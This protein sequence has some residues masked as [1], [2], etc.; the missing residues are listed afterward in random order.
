MSTIPVYIN[1]YN[2]LATVRAMVAYLLRVPQVEPVIVD[3]A[4]TYPPLLEWYAECPVRVVRLDCNLGPLGVWS[5][6]VDLHAS[7]YFGVTDP[8]LD[9][10]GIPV[11]CVEILCGGLDRYDDVKK[12]GLS[13]EIDDLPDTPVAARAREYEA[14]YWQVR[15]DNAFY[16]ANIDTTFAM[17]RGT[18]ASW[19]GYGPA[20]RA[21]RPYTARH[22]PWYVT[23]D[24]VTDEDLY[25]WEHCKGGVSYWG[26]Q[27]KHE[28]G[29]NTR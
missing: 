7:D 28:Y 29:V 27:L 4:S 18:R 26:A 23:P 19:G 5:S 9:L 16:L 20:L 8:D 15:R 11:D 25:Y 13:L 10:S 22:R 14:K 21:D 3:N 2:Q 17:Y 1:N 6:G 24:S 12:C